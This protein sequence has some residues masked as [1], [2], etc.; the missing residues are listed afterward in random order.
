MIFQ[1]E[2]SP[3]WVFIRLFKTILLFVK[4]SQCQMSKLYF[5]LGEGQQLL[6]AD[7]NGLSD[8]YAKIE[9]KVGSK[10]HNF[11]SKT[12]YKTLD[13]VWNEVF[14]VPHITVIFA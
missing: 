6:S 1:L 2:I 5:I 3:Y 12:I 10:K 9:I 4:T 14:E 7:S 11:K 8:P 13:P